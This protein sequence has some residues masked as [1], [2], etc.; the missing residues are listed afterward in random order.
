MSQSI[1][2]LLEVPAEYG[3]EMPDTPGN[4]AD[5]QKLLA[6]SKLHLVAKRAKKTLSA[7]LPEKAPV[8]MQQGE[9]DIGVAVKS[10]E[11]VERDYI[12]D[13]LYRCNG[14]RSKA[15]RMLN[16]SRRTL[17]RKMAHFG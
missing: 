10:L 9:N 5:W 3:A 12:V 2:L 8:T 6:G 13:I 1:Y 7:N 17:Q 14:N 16:I 15:A 4:H 11:E